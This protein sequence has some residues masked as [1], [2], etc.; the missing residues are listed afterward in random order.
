MIRVVPGMGEDPVERKK[1]PL[2]AY[3]ASTNALKAEPGVDRDQIDQM[4]HALLELIR[5]QCGVIPNNAN[6]LCRAADFAKRR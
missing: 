1:T 3:L 4:P 5:D 2:S 6:A